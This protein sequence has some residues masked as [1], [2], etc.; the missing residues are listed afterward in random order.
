MKRHLTQ[1]NKQSLALCSFLLSEEKKI[2]TLL[3]K[4]NCRAGTGKQRATVGGPGN[5]TSY[6]FA[7]KDITKNIRLTGR[8]RFTL[9]LL[10]YHIQYEAINRY[11]SVVNEMFRV[12]AL[13]CTF[14]IKLPKKRTF[15]H[16]LHSTQR[17][18]K[19]MSCG[20]LYFDE[21]QIMDNTKTNDNSLSKMLFYPTFIKTMPA[22]LY[23]FQMRFSAV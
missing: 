15:S 23:V 4:Q 1:L 5:H 9:N 2:A 7:P 21:Q 12:N 18:H 13:F 3:V 11:F 14:T 6:L 19:H 10:R 22:R 20:I 16:I 8:Y 17:S